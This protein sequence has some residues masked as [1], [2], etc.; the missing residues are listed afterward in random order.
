MV[1]GV[2]ASRGFVLKLWHENIKG[3]WVSTLQV[4]LVLRVCDV[5][6]EVRLV[7]VFCVFRRGYSTISTLLPDSWE[8]FQRFRPRLYHSFECCSRFRI[9]DGSW[10]VECKLASACLINL[11]FW[12]L[13][14]S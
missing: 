13:S 6:Y 7:V 10:A 9:S 12:V 14:N 2:S 4:Y 11:D 8:L 1:L 3:Y 5:L